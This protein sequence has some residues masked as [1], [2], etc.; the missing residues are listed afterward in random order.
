MF[1]IAA[2][3]SYAK[4]HDANFVLPHAWKY[5]NYF[6]QQHAIDNT[7]AH[8]TF[9]YTEPHFHYAPIAHVG[10]PQ[11]LAL[12]GYFQS[13]KYFF[14]KEYIQQL[15]EFE[16]TALEEAKEIMDEI[17]ANTGYTHIAGLHMRMGD[18]LELKHV[19]NCLGDTEYYVN[20]INYFLNKNPHTGFAVFSDDTQLAKEYFINRLQ[21]KKMYDNAQITFIHHED[22][23]EYAVED[24]ILGTLCNAGIAIGN[25]TYSLMMAHLNKNPNINIVAP[26]Q[27]F[28]PDRDWITD[29]VYTEEMVKM[30]LGVGS[31]K[32][33]VGSTKSE[34]GS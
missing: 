1:Q 33:E 13:H 17:K 32:M 15:F 14:S 11:T 10:S 28:G 3:T 31:G 30:G 20:A 21:L 26:A 16:E 29:D 24:L 18:Y 8:P 9:N 12:H 25:S 23:E 19:H 6:K 2:A 4:K 27:W 34:A 5:A 7:I 22:P